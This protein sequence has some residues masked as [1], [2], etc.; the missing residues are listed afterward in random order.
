MS[1]QLEVGHIQ[2]GPEIFL[3][4]IIQL[5]DFILA[6]KLLIL[7]IHYMKDMVIQDMWA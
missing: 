7:R 2:F 1:I 5:G 3:M 6:M 4:N